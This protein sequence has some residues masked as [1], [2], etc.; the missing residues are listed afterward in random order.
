MIGRSNESSSRPQGAPQE[1][2]SAAEFVD[3]IHPPGEGGETSEIRLEVQRHEG[4][5]RLDRFV[6][7]RLPDVSRS[8]IQQ[9]IAL[10]AIE[11][12]GA[13][14]L[15][16]HRLIGYELVTVVPQPRAAES[17]FAPDP[18]PV[19]VIHSDEH[20]LVIDKPPGLVTHPAAGHWRGT[21]MNGVLHHWPDQAILPR[22]GIVHR[23]DK[24]TSGLLVVARSELAIVRLV[25]QLADRSMSRRYLALVD[26]ETPEQGTI[27][28]PIGRDPQSPIRMAV[29]EVNKGRNAVTHFE[30][31]RRGRLST[32]RPVSLVLCQLQTGRT[33]QIRV[34]L[35]HQGFPLIGDPVYGRGRLEGGRAGGG[36]IAGFGRQ[37]LHAWR[38]GLIHPADGRRVSWASVIPVDLFQLLEQCQIDAS[39]FQEHTE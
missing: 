1:G 19:S 14:R 33:H 13:G 31:L 11:V 30:T 24:D 3:Y 10:G 26:G 25:A 35:Q 27:D 29:V 20:L 32:G 22:A 16:K 12:E 2:D 23:L 8:R 34:H 4:G 17:A 36:G 9:W 6:A 5:L 21:L 15:A 7:M 18:V 37:A 39:S 28:A 38:L